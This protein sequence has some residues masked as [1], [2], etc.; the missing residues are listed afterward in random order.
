MK[1]FGWISDPKMA[2]WVLILLSVWQFGSPM[3]IF[4]AGLKQIPNS[5]Y[6]AASLDGANWWQKF[7]R[8]TIPMI[9]PVIFF[10]LI[11]QTISGFMMF[12]PAY[13]ITRGGPFEKTMVYS[14]YM[15]LNGFK[16]FKMGYAS[17]LAWIL[18]LVLAIFTFIFFKT[19]PKWV[20]YETKGIF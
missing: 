7:G 10:N 4:I 19:A 13:I 9:S 5:L 2:L 12:V 11:M 18:L 15:Y 1:L 17:A 16:Y 14:L 3:L 20:Y 8:I 6:E